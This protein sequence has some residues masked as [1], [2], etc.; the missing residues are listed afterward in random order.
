VEA[1]ASPERYVRREIVWALGQFGPETWKAAVPALVLALGDPDRKVCQGAIHSL[2][3]MGRAAEPAIP[4]LMVHV[5]NSHFLFSR[6]AAWALARIGPAAVPA[7]VETL[8]AKDLFVRYEAMWSLG[9]MGAEARHAV[10]ALRALLRSEGIRRTAKVQTPPPAESK[11]DPTAPVF[12]RPRQGTEDSFWVLLI[13][14]LGGIGPDAQ[15]AVP[16]LLQ[17]LRE[18]YGTIHVLAARA[19]QQI[20]PTAAVQAGVA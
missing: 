8:W 14:T 1:L 20:D 7:L 17:L 6:L 16:E 15:E 13:T 2:G 4:A 9:Q 5:R 19:L 3:M 10:P 12:L 18:A 11:L